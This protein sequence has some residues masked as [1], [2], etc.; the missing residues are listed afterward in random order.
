MQNILFL[1]DFST[2][3]NNAMQYAIKVA[4]LLSSKLHIVYIYDTALYMESY[5]D[6]EKNTVLVNEIPDTDFKKMEAIE[7]EL[8]NHPEIEFQ[9]Y[10][11]V[12]QIDEILEELADDKKKWLVIVGSQ[13]ASES[14]DMWNSTDATRMVEQKKLTVISVPDAFDG[15]LNEGSEFVLATDFELIN[16]WS[17]MD[18]FYELAV[19]LKAKINVFNV[20][21]NDFDQN[22]KDYNKAIYADLVVFFKDVDIAMH[23]ATKEN[24]VEAIEDFAIKQNAKLVM[25]ITHKHS[26]LDE[27]FFKSITK[28]MTLNSQIPFMTIP[29]TQ[30]AELNKSYD[31]EY[32]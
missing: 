29:D 26:W 7:M 19:A 11:K 28:N 4:K 1:T 14:I 21:D 30:L 12:G 8:G 31:A 6:D 16:D 24:V 25:M 5:A 13:G 32:W 9:T 3:A 22:K 17:V 18:S 27:L 2:T 15:I 20:R 10:L 23:H